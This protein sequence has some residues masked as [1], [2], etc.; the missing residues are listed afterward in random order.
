MVAQLSHGEMRAKASGAGMAH[1]NPT[2]VSA[3]VGTQIQCT[4]SLVELRWLAPYSSSHW[5]MVRMDADATPAPS[6]LQQYEPARRSRMPLMQRLMS[7]I[8]RSRIFPDARLLELYPPFRPM[9]IK[10]L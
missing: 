2:T 3:M 7:M 8:V 4:T 10:V 9:G 5:F 6:A 1:R